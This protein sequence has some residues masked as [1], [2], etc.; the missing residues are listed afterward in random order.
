MAFAFFVD[1]NVSQG[2]P[3]GSQAQAGVTDADDGLPVEAGI[4]LP[5]TVDPATSWL[6]YRNGFRVFLDAGMALHKPLPQSPQPVDTLASSFVSPLD[7]DADAEADG[8]NTVSVG[9]FAD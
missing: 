1:E 6:A 8:M 2:F 4:L 5:W 7:A 3:P 9:N